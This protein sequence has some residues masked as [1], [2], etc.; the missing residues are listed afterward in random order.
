MCV[1]G[2]GA[3]ARL[4]RKLFRPVYVQQRHWIQRNTAAGLQF[5]PALQAALT[6][7]DGVRELQ[8]QTCVRGVKAQQWL[9]LLAVV[10]Q[11][12]SLRLSRSHQ[13]LERFEVEGRHVDRAKQ[14][15]LVGIELHQP[16]QCQ[17]RTLPRGWLGDDG[18]GRRIQEFWIQLLGQLPSQL[19]VTG[20]SAKQRDGL[21]QLCQKPQRALQPGAA[22]A[23][24]QQCFVTAHPA[25][26]AS[27]EQTAA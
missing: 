3:T 8:A 25:A 24:G 27:A 17:Q 19:Q 26:F 9:E 15:A 11:V 16:M 1:R 4:I 22:F 21:H 2:A 20:V 7:I 23:V 6:S 12:N 5:E 14:Y 10:G 13:I 18:D